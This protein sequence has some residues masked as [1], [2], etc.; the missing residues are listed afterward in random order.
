LEHESIKRLESNVR[1][2]CRD[3]PA[4]FK[5]AVNAQITASDGRHYI[6]FFAGAGALNYGHN[7]PR[8][9]AALIDHLQSDGLMHGL[10][11]AT[12]AKIEFLEKLE[13]LILKPRDLDYRVQFTGPTGT[14]AVE[15]A[16]KLAKK[17][18]K[19][20][21][22]IS[23]TN[24]YHGH[25]LGALALTGNQYFHDDLYGARN[26]V[27]VMPFDNYFADG[28]N[29]AHQLREL[30]NDSSSG[31]PLRRQING[32]ATFEASA[33]TWTSSSLLTIFRPATV[34]LGIFSVLKRLESFPISCV[35]PN[36]SVVACR[37][38][39]C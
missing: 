35:Y 17:A 25:S 1:S 14:N 28:A 30:L 13:L 5:S 26:N 36:L 23:F 27:S 3:F 10:D 8:A 39:Y 34:A 31:T 4:V 29:T 7:N 37:C 6:D 11:L 12:T 9:K 20:S 15:A 18:S 21:H 16:I 33:M 32:Y 2:Y 19:R 24:A 22:V 38:L